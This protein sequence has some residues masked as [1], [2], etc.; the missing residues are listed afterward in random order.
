M[1]RFPEDRVVGPDTDP[2]RSRSLFSVDLG[3]LEV[4]LE[5]IGDRELALVDG[6]IVLVPEPRNLHPLGAELLESMQPALRHM[7]WG[8]VEWKEKPASFPF[9]HDPC[10]SWRMMTTQRSTTKCEC[11]QKGKRRKVVIPWHNANRHG[12]PKGSQREVEL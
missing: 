4:F 8:A 9:A 7:W 12:R 10:G 5:L 3:N 2:T 11:G 1:T 6:R